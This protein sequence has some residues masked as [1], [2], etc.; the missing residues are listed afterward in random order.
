MKLK[1]LVAAL[2]LVA[3]TSQAVEIGVNGSKDYGYVSGSETGGGIT[4]G[5]KFGNVGVVAGWDRYDHTTNDQNKWSLMG[6][7][8]VA[9]FGATTVAV[10]AGA[11]YLDNNK[12]AD[13]YALLVGTGASYAI[14]KN[15]ALTADY[16]YQVGQKRVDQ[17]NGNTISAGLKYSF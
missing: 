9:K 8:D 2:A 17:F 12:V 5:Q 15:W 13:G 14:D 11:A 7:Y 10:K 1:L 4:V 6:S 16:R 3:G